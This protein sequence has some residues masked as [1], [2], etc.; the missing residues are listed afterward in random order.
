MPLGHDGD[1]VATHSHTTV[2]L[3]I[4]YGFNYSDRLHIRLWNNE[5][6]R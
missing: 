1:T 4:K 6:K 3:A 5:R 2:A